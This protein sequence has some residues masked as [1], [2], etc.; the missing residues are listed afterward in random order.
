MI[1]ALVVASVIAGV[2]LGRCTQSEGDTGGRG[3]RRHSTPMD[4]EVIERDTAAAYDTV[5]YIGPTPTATRQAGYR[6]FMVATRPG[7]SSAAASALWRENQGEPGRDPAAEA[8]GTRQPADTHPAA[9]EDA[10]HKSLRAE[11]L[12]TPDGGDSLRVRLP[13][14]QSVYEGE[15]Y[16]AYVSGVCARLDSLFVYPRRETVTVTVKKPPKRW[17]IGIAAGYAYTPRGFQPYVGFGVTYS[18]ISF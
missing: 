5:G 11:G 2:Y 13:V 16:R 15:E 7:V 18:I 6:E 1:F 4:L 9:K 8:A 14:T 17:H 10:G 3:A 12:A